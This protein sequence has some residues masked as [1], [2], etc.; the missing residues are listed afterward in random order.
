VDHYRDFFFPTLGKLGYDSAFKERTGNKSDGCATFFL[1]EKFYLSREIGLEL[2]DVSSKVKDPEMAREV[3]TDNV[4][5]ITVLD[6]VHGNGTPIVVVNCHLWWEAS[7]EKVRLYQ[8]QYIWLQIQHLKKEISSNSEIP[9]FF[10]GDFNETKGSAIKFLIEK[11]WRN[12]YQE[13]IKNNSSETEFQF[14]S[15]YTPQYSGLVDYIFASGNCIPTNVLALPTLRQLHNLVGRT[16][17]FTNIP[18]DHV[19]IMAKFGYNIN[20][21]NNDNTQSEIPTLPLEILLKIFENFSPPKIFQVMFVCGLWRKIVQEHKLELCCVKFPEY[22]NEVLQIVESH[23]PVIRTRDFTFTCW[24]KPKHCQYGM[25][26]SKDRSCVSQYQFRF[27]FH[28]DRRIAVAGI[29]AA[30]RAPQYVKSS[31]SVDPNGWASTCQTDVGGIPLN[32]WT[33]VTLLRNGTEISIYLN[34][35]LN[36]TEKCSIVDHNNQLPVRVGSRFPRGD[37][38]SAENPFQGEITNATFYFEALNE[39]EIVQILNKEKK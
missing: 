31:D 26:F 18:S 32:T 27:E 16:L 6:P 13:Y 23:V 14:A 12:S 3:L 8:V 30:S 2:N 28:F 38:S 21:N 36:C 7:A 37:G 4:A 9:I 22:N 19:H 34:G 15:I 11:G 25:I 20:N 24:L 29:G 35:K 5:L 1:R 10:C 39:E 33:H 17:P